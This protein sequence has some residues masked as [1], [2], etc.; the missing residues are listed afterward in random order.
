MKRFIPVPL[1]VI[2][3]LLSALPG[4]NAVG[5]YNSTSSCWW[6]GAICS[7]ATPFSLTSQNGGSGCS[8]VTTAYYQWNQLGEILSTIGQATLTV[9]VPGSQ[10]GVDGVIVTLYRTTDNNMPPSSLGAALGIQTLAN[11]AVIPT[12]LTFDADNAPG[13]PE[14]LDGLRAG[15]TAT[16]AV[17]ISN[18]TA[19]AAILEPSNTATLSLAKS[20]AVSLSTFM[21]LIQHP[22]DP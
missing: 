13:L 20:N 10:G 16:L 8:P 18:C 4:V 17:Q 21:P 3:L 2:A 12:T 15:G 9:S 22:I 1:V 11:P 14:Y 5:S 7:A 6:T 19:S